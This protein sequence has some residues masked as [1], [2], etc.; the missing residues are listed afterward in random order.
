M[1]DIAGLFDDART[2]LAGA[3]QDALGQ[4]STPR[5]VLGMKRQPRITAVGQAWHV[6]VLLIDATRVF[7]VGDIIRAQDPGR[8]GYTAESA[9]A[10]AEVRAAAV[11][12]KIPEGTVVHVGWQELDLSAAESGPLRLVDGVPM[13]RWSSAGGFT[14]LA[15]YLSERVD[16]LVHPL[17][18]AS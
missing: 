17:P 14:P 18:G 15:G 8:R 6:G 2:R 4:W 11:L 16:L 12:G 9:R 7:A 3:P 5:A 13:V 10:R 1:T